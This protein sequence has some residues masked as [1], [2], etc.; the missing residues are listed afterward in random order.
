MIPIAI[1]NGERYTY[2][3]PEHYKFIENNKIE[4]DTSNWTNDS[5]DPFDYHLAKSGER[6]FKTMECNQ[7][8]SSYPNEEA[9]EDEEEEDIWRAQGNL[10]DSVEQQGI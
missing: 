1:A 7:I 3:I 6:T 8:R 4:E 2:F 5:L 10:G 9:E